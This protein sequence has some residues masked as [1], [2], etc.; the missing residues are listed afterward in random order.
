M[1]PTLD[2]TTEKRQLGIKMIAHLESLP[3]PRNWQVTREFVLSQNKNLSY[4][5]HKFIEQV[6][7]ER[8]HL[9]KDTGASKSG[10]SRYLLS[11]PDFIYA[12]IIAI[13]KDLQ[14]DLNNPNKKASTKTWQQVAEAFPMYKVARKI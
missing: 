6:N 9:L 12:A 5:D 3:R 1:T 11:M 2:A 4:Q 7:E 10:D 14:D 8:K 13:D